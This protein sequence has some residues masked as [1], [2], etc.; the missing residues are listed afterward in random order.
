MIEEMVL[1]SFTYSIMTIAAI[2]SFM[3]IFIACSDEKTHHDRKN[4]IHEQY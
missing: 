2:I 4:R 1:D 3:I